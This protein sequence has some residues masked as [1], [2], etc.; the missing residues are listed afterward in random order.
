MKTKRFLLAAALTVTAAACTGNPTAPEAATRRP[1]TA[2]P[3]TSETT[4]PTAT[5]PI[6]QPTD[7]VDPGTGAGGSGCCPNG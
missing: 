5:N 6:T 1:G 2:A 3:S 4:E 7:P